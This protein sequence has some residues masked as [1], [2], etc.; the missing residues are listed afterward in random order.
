[1]KN[2]NKS[3]STKSFGILFFVF[4]FIIAIY[5]LKTSGEISLWFLLVSLIFLILG[6]SNSKILYPLKKYW[7]K[8]G[9]I[10]G[11]ITS[12]IILAFIFF[13]IV[14]PIGLLVR[15][16]QKDILNLKFNNNQSYWIKK[17][18]LKIKMKKQF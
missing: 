3:S 9:M 10:L 12:P 16:F 18:D 7:L 4:F 13:L 1:M 2:L 8:F 14:T 15:V 11:R 6:L 5:P 17:T